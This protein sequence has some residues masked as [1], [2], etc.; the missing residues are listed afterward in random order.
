VKF[1]LRLVAIVGV[2]VLAGVLVWHLTHQPK[3]VQAAVAK[4]KVVRAPAF[5]LPRLSGGGKLSLASL[6][7]KVVVLNFWQSACG[8]CKQEMPRL[9]AAARRWAGRNVVVVGVDMLDSRSAGRSFVK[10]YGATYPMVFDAVADT[11]APYGVYGTPQ[12]FFLSPR[13][14]IV[15]R[16]LGPVSTA[17]FDAGVRSALT[18]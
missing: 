8:P 16:V 11:A 18:T 10:R 12:T 14:L 2:G 1:A 7:G 3:S 6:R 15:K 4:G 5:D 9:E 13:G 17:G